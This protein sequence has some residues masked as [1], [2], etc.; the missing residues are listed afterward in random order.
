MQVD[1]GLIIDLYKDELN[2]LMNENI[3]L[4]AQIK[5]LQHELEVINQ[6]KE[7]QE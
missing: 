6:N 2:K 5:Q 3:L 4:K 7:K 1:I